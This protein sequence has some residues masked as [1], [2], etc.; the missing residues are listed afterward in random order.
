[1]P[2]HGFGMLA[3]AIVIFGLAVKMQDAISALVVFDADFSSKRDQRGA[4]V[5]RD[6][7]GAFNILADPPGG[8]V[9]KKPD[10]PVP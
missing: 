8:A 5:K 2:A 9:D 7:K 4:A 10:T 3:G 1:M 6:T